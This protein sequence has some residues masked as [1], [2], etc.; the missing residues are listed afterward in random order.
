MENLTALKSFAEYVAPGE[1]G[2]LDE[3]D[4]GHGAIV[5]HGLEKLAAYRDDQGALHLHSAACSHV[6]CHLHWNSFEVCWD[7]PCHGS[8]FAIDG[9]PINAPAISSLNPAKA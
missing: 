4:R 7:C 8:M 6:G 2:S 9:Q 5:R 1:I 3:L